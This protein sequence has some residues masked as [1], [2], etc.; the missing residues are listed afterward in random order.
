VKPAPCI[1]TSGE[2]PREPVRDGFGS[3]MP[4]WAAS[5][6]WFVGHHSLAPILRFPTSLYRSASVDVNAD[7]P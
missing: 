1:G 6:Q 5:V 2:S 7:A 3:G 4:N